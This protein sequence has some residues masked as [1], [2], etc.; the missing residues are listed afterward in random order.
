MADDLVANHV[1]GKTKAELTA[2]LG[3]EVPCPACQASEAWW[4]VG[5][6]RGFLR[7]DNTCVLAEFDQDGAATRARVTGCW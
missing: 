7:F 5:L 4:W 3:P 1:A 2:L 6:E